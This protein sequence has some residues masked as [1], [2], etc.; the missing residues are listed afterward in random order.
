MIMLKI[1]FCVIGGTVAL[2]VALL[3][4]AMLIVTVEAIVS[5]YVDWLVERWAK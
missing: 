1:F 4:V 2:A 3:L 5:K